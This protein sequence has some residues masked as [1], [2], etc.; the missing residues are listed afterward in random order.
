MDKT[1]LHYLQTHAGIE[2]PASELNGAST[3]NKVPYRIFLETVEQAPIAISITDKKANILYVN[4]EFVKVTGYQPA[5]ILGQNESVLSDKITPR[6]VYHDLW[7]TISRKQ[8]WQGRLIN[9]HKQGARYLSDLTIAPMLDEQGII[10]HYIGMHRDITATYEAEKKAVNQK[11]LI[12]SVI[13][14]S[15]FAMVVVD[16]QDRVILDNQLY[17]ALVSDLGKGEPARYFL[18]LLREDM[19]DLWAQLQNQEQGFNHREFRI[20]TRGYQGVRWFSCAGNWFLEKNINA[21]AFFEDSSKHYLVLTITDITKQRRQME[22][23]HIQTLKTLM[24]EDERVRSIR[25]T[26]LGAIHQI[27]MPM[28]Q[29]KAAESILRYKQDEKNTGLLDI[30]QQIQ[31]SG[32]AAVATMQKCIPEIFQT[33]VTPINLNQ[34]LHEVML[35]SDQRLLSNNIDVHWQPQ[36]NLP[37]LLGSENRLR[38]LFKQLIDNAIEAMGRSKSIDRKTNA[39]RRLA[40]TTDTDGDLIYVTVEDTGPGIPT[41]KRSKVFEPF[42]TTQ[43]KGMGQTGMGLVIAREIVNQHQGLIDIDAN[44]EEGCRLKI[45]FPV[46]RVLV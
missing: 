36:S 37:S 45:S 10:S 32:D 41:D 3:V 13:N 7:H 16:D 46:R 19:G 27:Q 8:I 43:H 14:S 9:R 31:Q 6:H 34:I 2:E 29:I 12:E 44:Y 23:L 18:R 28:N 40:I 25:E 30:L 20:E 39:I 17:K 38:I 24:A 1:S 22:A 33:A 26:L 21:D 15:P 11:L 5:D 42:Y 4:E 35:L